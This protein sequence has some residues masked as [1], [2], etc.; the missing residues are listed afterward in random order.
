ME[1]ALSDCKY[2][3]APGHRDGFWDS[4]DSLATMFLCIF[5][6]INVLIFLAK[7]SEIR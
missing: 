6:T 5:Y 2:L 7:K 1:F 3:G 4:L